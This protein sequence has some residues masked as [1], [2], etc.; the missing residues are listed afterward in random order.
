V[1]QPIYW[2]DLFTPETWEELAGIDY[3]TSG[4]RANRKAHAAKVRPG[5]FFLCYL[6]G[7][8]RFVGILEVLSESFWDEHPIW[9]SDVFPVRFRTRRV[10]IVAQ[11]RGIH[12]HEVSAQSAKAASWGGYVRGSPKRLPQAD[13][14]FIVASLK[15]IEEETGGME[16]EPIVGIKVGGDEGAMPGPPGDDQSATDH[17]R[18]QYRLLA[19]GRSLGLDLWVARDNRSDSYGGE[20][21]GDMAVAELPIRFDDTTRGTI[22][23]IDVLWLAQNRI[24]AAFE[25]ESTTSIYSGLLR[26]ADLLAMQPNI[27]IPLFI[28]APSGRRKAVLN[29][30]KRPVFASLPTP[31]SRACGYIAFDRLERELEMLGDRVNYLRPDFVKALAENAS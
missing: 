25:I 9:Q 3:A 7:K 16:D 30:I 15:R 2:L 13:G 6:T 19:L 8:S 12:L 10:C 5:D 27:E 20:R 1:A 11:D 26:M 24:E 29:E 4:F 23:R 28:V 22:E 17:D 18:I 21:F 14:D 31:L